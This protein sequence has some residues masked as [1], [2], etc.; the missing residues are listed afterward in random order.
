M[1]KVQKK[2]IDKALE[3]F[4]L[5]VCHTIYMMHISLK[6]LIK[7]H[8]QKDNKVVFDKQ[9]PTYT[10]ERKNVITPKLYSSS[11]KSFLFLITVLFKNTIKGFL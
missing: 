5:S 9:F 10:Y 8:K 4:A 1:K 7:F 3:K 2:F 11:K 6:L